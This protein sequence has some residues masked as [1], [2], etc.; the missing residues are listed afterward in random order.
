MSRIKITTDSTADIPAALQRELDISIL[1][2][3][4]IIEG[5]EYLDGHDITPQKFYGILKRSEILPTTSQATPMQYI[6]LFEEV[7]RSG[8]TDQIHTC[9]NSKASATWY[10]AIQARE[11]FYEEYP[12]ARGKFSIHII[13]S[14]NYTMAYGWGV[15]EGARLAQKGGTVKEVIACIQG[16]VRRMRPIYVPLNLRVV[17]KSGRV[18]PVAAFVGDALG[19]KPVITFIEGEPRIVA[20]IRGAGRVVKGLLDIVCRDRRP[21]TPYLLVSGTSPEH[22]AKLRETC[23]E[24][25]G[26][27]PEMEYPVGCVIALN[28]GTE[29]VGIVYCT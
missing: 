22:S 24:I 11:L 21:D 27:S 9:L 4:L 8:Y 28:S 18:S 19:L 15:V 13:D 7:W 16:W 20:K 26:R 2:L 1:P 29:G 10:N 5:R 17:R 3:H 25:L 23:S 14:Q 6:E 12:E